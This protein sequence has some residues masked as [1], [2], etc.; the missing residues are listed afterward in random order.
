[1]TEKLPVQTDFTQK[2]KDHWK[3]LELL[4]MTKKNYIVKLN[5]LSMI[6]MMQYTQ[7]TVTDSKWIKITQT[8]I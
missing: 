4:N 6:F 2:G 8:D 3:L 7:M 1:M 5:Y